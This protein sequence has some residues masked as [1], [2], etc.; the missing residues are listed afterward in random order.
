MDATKALTAETVTESQI[1]TLREECRAEG[2]TNLADICDL[3]LA[4][5]EDSDSQGDHLIAPHGEPVTRSWAR[6]IC[7][8]AIS[9]TEHV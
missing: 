4:A 2:D 8:A 3:A 7:A 9:G 1:K 6:G 5:N